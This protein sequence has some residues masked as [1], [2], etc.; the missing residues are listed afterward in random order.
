[1]IE[2]QIIVQVK[3]VDSDTGW[4]ETAVPKQ[5]PAIFETLEEAETYCDNL[6]AGIENV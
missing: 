5:C 2:F 4:K 1:M 6:M 3:R